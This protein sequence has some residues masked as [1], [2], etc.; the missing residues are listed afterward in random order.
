ME[1]G[2]VLGKRAD[3][4]NGL[5]GKVGDAK[6]RLELALVNHLLE[7]LPEGLDLTG[8]DNGRVVD[9]H[10]VGVRTHLLERAEDGR[11]D[12]V[13]REGL[14]VGNTSAFGAGDTSCK[15]EGRRWVASSARE[16]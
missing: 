2:L 5:G 12:L 7:F 4:L 6:R 15:S 3:L 16:R 10:D 14:D 13:D 9:H 11:A 8:R 1:D